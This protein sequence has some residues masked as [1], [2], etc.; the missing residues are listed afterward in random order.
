MSAPRVSGENVSLS[1]PIGLCVLG[2]AAACGAALS[3]TGRAMAQVEGLEPSRPDSSTSPPPQPST[4]PPA[5]LSPPPATAS[6]PAPRPCAPL[7]VTF[8][9]GSPNASPRA[10]AATEGLGNWLVA[11]PN[12]SVVIDGHADAQGDALRNLELSKKRAASIGHVLRKRGVPRERLTTR[13]FGAFFPV[14]GETDNAAANRRVVVRVRGLG[15]C[16]F[17]AEEVIEP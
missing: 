17:E 7:V 1:L 4:C 12:R 15:D 6:T 14:E 5:A 11:H 13:G 9:W 2:F 8:S 3:W 10:I 16:P